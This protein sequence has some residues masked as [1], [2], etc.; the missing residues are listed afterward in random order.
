MLAR[1]SHEVWAVE[2][3]SQGWRYG[4]TRD[5]NRKL[6]PS[7]FQYQLVKR[8][9]RLNDLN[10]AKQ[11]ILVVRA[12]GYSIVRN[13]YMRRKGSA[14]STTGSMNSATQRD[15]S[16]ARHWFDQD[17]ATV[18]ESVLGDIPDMTEQ[19]RMNLIRSFV[20]RPVDT[21]RVQVRLAH[22]HTQSEHVP[23]HAHRSC[24]LTLLACM[25]VSVACV[26]WWP[27]NGTLERVTRH[28]RQLRPELRALVEHLARNQHEVWAEGK[29]KEGFTYAPFRVQ[30][31]QNNAQPTE[32]RARQRKLRA[33]L[34]NLAVRGAGGRSFACKRAAGGYAPLTLLSRSQCSPCVPVLPRVGVRPVCLSF[35]GWVDHPCCAAHRRWWRMT[36]RMMTAV[37]TA[38]PPA[39]VTNRRPPRQ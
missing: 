6:H 7:L 32:G 8:E 18:L 27:W 12:M 19:E 20:P 5:D 9:N 22:P 38:T 11:A 39:P 37:L 23:S 35:L 36:F 16:R 30:D 1:N 17:E 33:E 4:P 3:M 14:G 15:A 26:A 28:L 13:K 34:N 24:G 31:S 2:R 25:C 10:Q 21:S 29:L